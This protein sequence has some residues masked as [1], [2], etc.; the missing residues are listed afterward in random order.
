MLLGAVLL[1]KGVIFRGN[2]EADPF[3]SYLHLNNVIANLKR[4]VLVTGMY[5]SSFDPPNAFGIVN[6][7]G[8]QV[9]EEIY[10]KSPL[11]FLLIEME[12]EPFDLEKLRTFLL[13]LNSRREVNQK[14]DLQP[15]IATIVNLPVHGSGPLRT[16]VSQGLDLGVYGI[17][18][19]M[20]QNAQ[21][22]REAVQACRFPQARNCPYPE[23]AGIRSFYLLWAS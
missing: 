4:D 15:N 3:D 22:A 8:W 10:T 19:P 14:G 18:A 12:H 20:I 2:F 17:N 13:A 9:G 21:Q 16:Y 11:D 6:A 7:N 1:L 23:P 5:V